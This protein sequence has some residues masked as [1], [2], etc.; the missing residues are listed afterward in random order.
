M[1]LAKINQVVLHLTFPA[2]VGT[3]AVLQMRFV[4]G[5]CIFVVIVI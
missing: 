1:M 3:Y 2:N 5:H 4:N